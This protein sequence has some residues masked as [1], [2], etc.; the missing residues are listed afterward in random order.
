MLLLQLLRPCPLWASQ[1]PCHPASP[2]SPGAKP[3]AEDL[4]YYARGLFCHPLITNL[5]G[6]RGKVRSRGKS[7]GKCG[8]E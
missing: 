4:R 6:L 2:A 1:T 3:P 5:Q 8:Q 7:V